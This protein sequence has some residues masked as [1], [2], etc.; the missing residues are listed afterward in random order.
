MIP[1]S[2]VFPGDLVELV[3]YDQSVTRRCN[4]EQNVE[5]FRT[6]AGSIGIVMNASQLDGQIMSMRRDYAMQTD[7]LSGF[8]VLFGDR[9]VFVTENEVKVLELGKDTPSR[10]ERVEL[11]TVIVAEIQERTRKQHLAQS[12]SKKLQSMKNKPGRVLT[13]DKVEIKL[14]KEHIEVMSEIL[15]QMKFLEEDGK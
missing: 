3:R 14:D 11:L 13:D 6:K 12:L 9:L 8:K 10:E 5:R 4:S 15:R 7:P 1:T 2:V